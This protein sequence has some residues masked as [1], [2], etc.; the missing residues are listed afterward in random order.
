MAASPKNTAAFVIHISEYIGDTSDSN[1]LATIR[2]SLLM[3]LREQLSSTQIRIPKIPLPCF[4]KLTLRSNTNSLLLTI[5]LFLSSLFFLSPNL[6]R[7]SLGLDLWRYCVEDV[8]VSCCAKDFGVCDQTRLCGKT[9]VSIELWV[10]GKTTRNKLQFTIPVLQ[11]R[12]PHSR[13]TVFPQTT[14]ACDNC[15]E[16]D[17]KPSNC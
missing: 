11:P 6:G 5:M 12:T 10:S 15:S 14:F 13:H 16:P 4:S 17:P 9:W 8:W 1:W 2:A 7:G 3:I